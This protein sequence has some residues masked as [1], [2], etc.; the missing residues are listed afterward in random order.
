MTNRPIRNRLAQ[1]RLTRRSPSPERFDTGEVVDL[2]ADARVDGPCAEGAETAT[3]RSPASVHAAV[4][5][6]LCDAD[7][8]PLAASLHERM[9]IS[10]VPCPSRVALVSVECGGTRSTLVLDRGWLDLAIDAYNTDRSL[11]DDLD[12]PSAAI[13][14]V[15]RS[16]PEEWLYSSN[17]G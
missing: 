7:H 16:W 11:V 2:D 14:T 10:A 13:V 8:D 6:D 5:V 3:H 1:S 9:T 15:L 4:V 17:P 12:L